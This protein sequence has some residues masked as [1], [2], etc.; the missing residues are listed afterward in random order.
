LASLATELGTSRDAAAIAAA[1]ALP[2]KPT[3]L[4]GAV[5]V[6]QLVSNLGALAFEGRGLA[7]RLSALEQP[8]SEYWQERSSLSWQ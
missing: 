1:L 6:D 3:V 2:S 5:T 8:A 4:L 7:E